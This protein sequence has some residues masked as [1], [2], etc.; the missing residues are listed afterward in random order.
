[1]IRV[2]LTP[3]LDPYVRR[4]RDKIMNY[5]DR[6]KRPHHDLVLEEIIHPCHPFLCDNGNL[7]LL[8]H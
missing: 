7:T 1:V 2:S 8:F 5:A 3:R 6:I 4:L